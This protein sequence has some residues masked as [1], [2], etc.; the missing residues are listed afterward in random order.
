MLNT[1][2]DFEILNQEKNI[3]YRMIR[4][5]DMNNKIRKLFTHENM[6]YLFLVPSLI[7]LATFYI[8]PFGVSIYFALIDNNA[9]RQ[10]VGLANLI[11]IWDNRAFTIALQN[12]VVFMGTSIPLNVA[13]SLMLA[14]MLKLIRPAARRIL[15]VLFLLPLVIPSASVIFFWRHLISING[16]LNRLFFY[17]TPIDWLN[18]SYAM[19]FI[20]LIFIW[21]NIGFNV[22]LIRAGLDF[23]PKEYY[24]FAAIEGAGCIRQFFMVTLIYLRPTFLLVFILSVV[25]S[26]KV[27]REIYLLTGTHPNLSIY[28]MQHFLNNQFTALN[29]QRMASA[30]IYVFGFILILVFVLYRLQQRQSYL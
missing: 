19:M 14:L 12:T 27:F 5:E 20:V 1:A 22:I 8:V 24:E 16:M 11:D 21:K 15:L 2:S 13:L 29:Y 25:N 3:R 4:R 10:F 30:S 28:M 26:F 23:I 7:G 6:I 17:T 18:S 9:S